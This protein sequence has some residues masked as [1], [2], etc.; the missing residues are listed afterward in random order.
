[1]ARGE[2]CRQ[3]AA[4]ITRSHTTISREVRHNGGPDG[5]RAEHADRSAWKRARRPKP[6]KLAINAMLR[7]IVEDKLERKWS[8]EQIALWLKRTYPDCEAMRISH[9]TI[10]LSLF[11]QSRGALRR[12]LTAQLRSGR[13]TRRPQ[14]RALAQGRGQIV[15]K[16]MISDRPA[17][18]D[19]RAVPGHWEGDLLLGTVPT[20]I[21]TLVERSTRYMQ[22]VEVPDATAPKRYA[23]R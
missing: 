18:A 7:A 21:A 9:E 5:Y 6:A 4:S 11:V 17:E 19:D 14:A 10:Y 12:E 1:M 20:A 8:P 15:G 13:V 3:I 16:L 2:S 22:L 23:M